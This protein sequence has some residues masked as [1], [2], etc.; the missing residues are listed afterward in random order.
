M[1]PD[2]GAYTTEVLSAYAVSLL[3]LL[4]IVVIS[5]VHGRRARADLERIERQ[6]RIERHET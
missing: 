2:L 1:M 5:V 4:G 3:C 6:E